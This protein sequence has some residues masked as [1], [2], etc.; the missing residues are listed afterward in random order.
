MGD[1]R[2]GVNALGPLV[3]IFAV[4]GVL[5]YFA[6]IVEEKRELEFRQPIVDVVGVE[7]FDYDKIARITKNKTIY[8]VQWVESGEYHEVNILY[9]MTNTGGDWEYIPKREVI[10]LQ[11]SENHD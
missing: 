11:R 1:F 5:L 4:L 6:G 10:V 3:I 2:D 8:K 7:D 9:D